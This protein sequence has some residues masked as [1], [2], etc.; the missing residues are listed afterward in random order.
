MYEVGDSPLVQEYIQGPGYGYFSLG[1]S[2]GEPLVTFCHKRLR[3]YP[4]SGGPSTLCESVY[5]EK[6]I[7]LGT[8]ML[9]TLK[10]K[11]VAMVEFKFDQQANEYKFLEVNPRFWGSLPL[12]LRCGVNFPA[13]L[14]QMA[15]GDTPHRAC[16]YPV[17]VKVRFL[18]TDIPAAWDTWRK[19]KTLSF[20]RQYIGELLD[21]S[22]KDG[23]I[24]GDDLAPL[25][26]YIRSKLLR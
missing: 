7:D 17:G 12:A 13:Y 15:L 6:L 19:N 3:E 5:D 2:S 14:V 10:L 11:G 18:F 24:Q 20:V 21:F 4:I 1:G 8:K 26:A 16:G 22:I 25:G 9:T 23:L